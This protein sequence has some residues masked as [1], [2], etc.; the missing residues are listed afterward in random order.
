MK[1]RVPE[2]VTMKTSFPILLALTILVRLECPGVND[3]TEPDGKIRVYVHWDDTPISGKKVELVQAGEVQWTSDKGRMEFSVRPGH[4]TVR[5]HDINRG[6][7]SYRQ[8][9]FEI[10]VK[11]S[12]TASVDVVDCL[13]CV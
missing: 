4:Y 13:P 8:I 6:G 1:E 2:N 12:A 5:V 9:D 11:P 7:P 10:D 3:G